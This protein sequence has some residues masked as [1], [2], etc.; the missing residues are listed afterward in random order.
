MM[1][2]VMNIAA[3]AVTIGRANERER[4]VAYLRKLAD[5]APEEDDTVT[6]AIIADAIEEGQHDQ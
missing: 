5:E 1:Q 6:L 3:D 4:V 2:D